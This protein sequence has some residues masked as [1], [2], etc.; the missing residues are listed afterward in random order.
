MYFVKTPN[1]SKYIK[2]DGELL[3]AVDIILMIYDKLPNSMKVER[4]SYES[5]VGILFYLKPVCSEN[6]FYKSSGYYE[7]DMIVMHKYL[8]ICCRTKY[9][10]NIENFINLN[11]EVYEKHRDVIVKREEY[12]ERYVDKLKNTYQ[13]ELGY[14]YEKYGF[15]LS[16]DKTKV[17]FREYI[18]KCKEC[19]IVFSE[20]ESYVC[21][22]ETKCSFYFEIEIE[23]ISKSQPYY[24]EITTNLGEKLKRL[25]PFTK[26]YIQYDAFD[27]LKSRFCSIIEVEDLLNP[28]SWDKDVPKHIGIKK[29]LKIY[30]VHIGMA[31]Q[32]KKIGSYVEFTKKI[33]PYIHSVGYNVIQVMAILEH[34]HYGSFGYQP[35]FAYAPS[36][37]FG[38]SNDFKQL[39]E[40][41]HKLNIKVVLD[42]MVGHSAVNKLDGMNEFNGTDNQFFLSK[43]H[44]LWCSKMYDFSKPFVAQYWLSN[45]RY[46][47][48]EFHIDGFRF[49]AVTA[50]LFRDYGATK[51]AG[52]LACDFFTKEVNIDGLCF[53][54]FCNELIHTYKHTI[55]IAEDVSGFPAL[56]SRKFGLG[57][58]YKLGMHIPDIIQK[59]FPTSY[60]HPPIY[61]KNKWD[62]DKLAKTFL[63]PQPYPT[64]SYI[65]SHDQAFVGGCTLFQAIAQKSA[66]I[67]AHLSNLKKY[68]LRNLNVR[69]ATQYSMMFRTICYSVAGSGYLT[70][71]GNE[72][73]H[74]E[75]IEFPCDENNLSFDKCH[76]KW[77]LRKNKKLQ[78][79]NMMKYETALHNLATKSEWLSSPP[80]QRVTY[81]HN[82]KQILIYRKL[83]QIFVFCFHTSK[84]VAK[85][86]I[87]VNGPG[88]YRVELSTQDKQ[89]GG[90]G[91]V[92]Q[93]KV[94]ESYLYDPLRKKKMIHNR[95]SSGSDHQYNY[96]IVVDIY[97]LSGMIISLL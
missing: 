25:S 3:R 31:Q 88:K 66:T 26:R 16:D 20:S 77:S 63:S 49:D 27:V 23:R 39:V 58:D 43:D 87:K 80:H 11:P 47:I 65:E 53:L 89:F 90:S 93:N 32:E 38:T 82:E 2:I 68:S 24:L 9:H 33:L 42:I 70:F 12:Y 44:P 36:S 56:C 7:E 78:F 5:D 92:V 48:E 55:T 64:I 8:E 14:G 1:S 76:R 30:E 50:V 60:D 59:L 91:C 54:R 84:G 72:F 34:P 10:K 62:I 18:E 74:P 95:L 94:Y 96:H 4:W 69:M 40:E 21:I 97:P 29:D 13:D 67:P 37:R 28:F 81:I 85:H 46:W 15:W 86:H 6:G 41:A 79:Y 51:S 61:E 35:N 52:E 57:F 22:R 73:G 17:C 45:I 19:K 75:W 71:M 83:H